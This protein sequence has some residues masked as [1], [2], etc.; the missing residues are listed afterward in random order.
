MHDF[1]QNNPC[2]CFS[3]SS[4]GVIIEA[5]QT[6]CKFLGYSR[7]ELIGQKA[8]RIFSLATRIF[9]Q[10]HFYPLLQLKGHAEEIYITLKTKSSEDVAV[11]INAVRTDVGEGY[12]LHYAGIPIKERKK[13]EDELVAAKNAAEKALTENTALKAAKDDLAKQSTMLDNQVT[14]ANIQNQELRQ[15]NHL[16]THTLQE[17]VRKLMYFSSAFTENGSQ[18]DVLRIRKIAED[19]QAK[20]KGL[21]QYVW[22]SNEQLTLE[23]VNI[24]ELVKAEETKIRFEN[25]DLDLSIESNEIPIIEACKAQVGVLIREILANAVQFRQ[26]GNAV[27]VT[28]YSSIVSLNQFRQM[29]E[30]YKYTPYLKLTIQDF[31]IGFNDKYQ[32]QAFEFFRKLHSG[33]GQGVGLSF[34][35]K[36]M[37]N[38]KGTISL[39]SQPDRGTNVILYLPI[40]QEK[41][42]IHALNTENSTQ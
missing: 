14:L 13:Y 17:P 9:Q 1:Y 30:Q 42:Y 6:L 24:L 32:E 10:T 40:K 11:L 29:S 3:S 16:V 41:S 37:E 18:K 28:I 23:E 15:I 22:L 25:P 31:G 7:E 12:H 20:L 35:K 2:V 38:H 36:I 19:M 21:Q 27:Q 5:N 8:E 26:P 39:E 34:C 33:E 4:E